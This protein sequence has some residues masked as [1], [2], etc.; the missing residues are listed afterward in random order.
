MLA[1]RLARPQLAGL[2][3]RVRLFSTTPF[4]AAKAKA[5]S[6]LPTVPKA[7]ISAFSYYYRDFASK[8][9]SEYVGAEGKVDGKALV[10]AAS[11]HWSAISE[12]EKNVYKEKGAK[13]RKEAAEAYV[14]FW[15][16]T[17]PAQRRLITRETGKKL[18]SPKEL[19]RPSA[20]ARAKI[21]ES[22][23]ELFPNIDKRTLPEVPKRHQT[24]YALFFSDF[25]KGAGAGI[26]AKEGKSGAEILGAPAGKAWG[27]LPPAE[28]QAYVD[29]AAELRAAG[30]QAYREFWESTSPDV[31]AK[32]E[33][34]TGKVLAHPD[35]KRSYNKQIRERPGNPGQP[36]GA[37]FEFLEATRSAKDYDAGGRSVA[38]E[39]VELGKKWRA[40]SP[41]EKKRYSEVSAAKH[42]KYKEWFATQPDLVAAKA[43]KQELRRHKRRQALKALEKETAKS[44]TPESD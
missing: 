37:F 1:L 9:K 33:I 40:L 39:A 17:T 25:V 24:G 3:A 12:K 29:K 15:N 35:G 28:K 31:R 23:A 30:K 7:G 34:V 13:S 41:E 5:L 32:I 8:H 26:I 4:V 44:E 42:V 27:E 19:G 20:A 16:N 10:A 38:E 43:A 2:T 14:E 6:D 21:A 11:D 18:V 36:A 22:K